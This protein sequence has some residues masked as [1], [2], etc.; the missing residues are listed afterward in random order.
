M[1]LRRGFHWR[2][3]RI[4]HARRARL[5]PPPCRTIGT[6]ADTERVTKRIKGR[7][8][9]FVEIDVNYLY[10]YSLEHGIGTQET[11]EAHLSRAETLHG[12]WEHANEKERPFMGVE[13]KNTYDN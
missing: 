6:R 12:T 11:I 9:R 3:S 8:I 10:T 4:T 7:Q 1:G 5:Y 13:R 2:G